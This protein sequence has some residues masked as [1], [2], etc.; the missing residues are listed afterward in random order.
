[1]AS[2]LLVD[3][4]FVVALLSRRDGNHGWAAEYRQGRAESRRVSHDFAA[5][6]KEGGP[7]WCREAHPPR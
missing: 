2:S 3:A 4:G 7:S 1:M 6:D 5:V